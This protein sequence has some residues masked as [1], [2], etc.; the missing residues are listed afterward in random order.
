[1]AVRHCVNKWTKQPVHGQPFV[2]LYFSPDE[3]VL[4]NSTWKKKNSSELFS[5]IQSSTKETETFFSLLAQTRQSPSPSQ[6][7][8]RASGPSSRSEDRQRVQCESS[9]FTNVHCS[10]FTKPASAG[11]QK[12]KIALEN[13]QPI[14]CTE[15]SIYGT[16]HYCISHFPSIRPH[17]VLFVCLSPLKNGNGACFSGWWRPTMMITLERVH[18]GSHVMEHCLKKAS[19]PWCVSTLGSEP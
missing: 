16:E 1:M 15:W 12:K 10:V 7:P 11:T 2:C 3:I 17:S 5:S 6:C 13:L 18:V 19:P 8:F 9:E 14:H 4:L